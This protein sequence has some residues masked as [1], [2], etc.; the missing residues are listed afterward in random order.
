M[1]ADC[2]IWGNRPLIAP[3]QSGLSGLGGIW[4]PLS[5]QSSSPLHSWWAFH[6]RRGLWSMKTGSGIWLSLSSNPQPASLL[7]RAPEKMDL[8]RWRLEMAPG[9]PYL[10]KLLPASFQ[11]S[12]YHLTPCFHFMAFGRWRLEL[13]SGFPYLAK[14]LPPT[15]F[16]LAPLHAP[17]SM[18]F[19]IS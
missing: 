15:S 6:V 12:F 2:Q 10:A 19:R 14:L 18:E 4:L 9:F 8:G 1:Y 16:F 17:C 5:S 7:L 3:E 13:A 11:L